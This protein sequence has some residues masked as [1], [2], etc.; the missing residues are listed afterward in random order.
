MGHITHTCTKQHS[1]LSVSPSI[2]HALP[3]NESSYFTCI[4]VVGFSANGPTLLVPPLLLSTQTDRLPRSH[5]LGHWGEPGGPSTSRLEQPHKQERH[6]TLTQNLKAMG[7]LTYK[8]FN[9]YSFIRRGT[10][11]WIRWKITPI[12]TW[13]VEQGIIK[14]PKS[15]CMEQL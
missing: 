10:L 5:P 7:P 6:H 4:V 2:H 3:S 8:V 15:K 13:C 12:T 9:L 1:P 14:Q 11:L